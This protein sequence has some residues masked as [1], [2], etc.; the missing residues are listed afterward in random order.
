LKPIE[1]QRRSERFREETRLLLPAIEPRL[2]SF[3]NMPT[4]LRRLQLQI[5]RLL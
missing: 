2:H 3:F 1:T 4:E 5:C